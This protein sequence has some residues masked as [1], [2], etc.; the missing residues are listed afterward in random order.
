MS[1]N[2]E[3]CPL[4]GRGFLYAEDK[5]RTGFVRGMFPRKRNVRIVRLAADFLPVLQ[6]AH[7]KERGEV[8]EKTI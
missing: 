5:E 2:L 3:H 4:T 7:R 8:Y 6:W 1:G